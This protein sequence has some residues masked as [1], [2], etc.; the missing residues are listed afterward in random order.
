MPLTGC[1][2]DLKIKV[3][4]SQKPLGQPGDSVPPQADPPSLALAP[5]LRHEV[6]PGLWM[7][8]DEHGQTYLAVRSGAFKP[9]GEHTYMRERFG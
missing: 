1:T 5:R 7:F 2:S 4:E 8:E 3:V 9:V 6:V